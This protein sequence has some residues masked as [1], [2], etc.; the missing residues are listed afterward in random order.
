MKNHL[1]KLIF[2]GALATSVTFAAESKGA[3]IRALLIAGGCCHDY[4]GQ[5]K[6][7]S[8]GI[9]ERANV[10]VDV[11]WTDDKSV[12]PP[13]PIYED[14]NWA[15]GYDVVIHDE[16]AAGNKDLK[17]MENI[18]NAHKTVPAVHLH[19]A[20]HSFRN[21]TDQWFKH[22]GL[23]STRHGPQVPIK[24]EF[25]DKEHPIT[26]TL[27]DWTTI[28]EELYNSPKLYDAHT[29]ARGTQE[30]KGGKKE[31]SVVVWTNEKQGAR[32][33]STSL[34]HNTQTVAD[35]RYLDLVTRGLLWACDKL[36]EE[37]LKPYKGENKVTF[38]KSSEQPTAAP[39]QPK[40]TAAPKDATLVKMT[41]SSEESNKQNYAWKATDGNDQTRW[42]AAGGGLPAW[43]Q[44]E[45]D[46]PTT[47]TSAAIKWEVRN[48]W[49]QYKIDVSSDGKKW[50]TV[51]DKSNN[52]KGGDT[53]DEFEA[54]DVKFLRVTILKQQSSKWGSLWEVQVTGP[55]IK[56]IF[57]NVDEK[58]ITAQK[59]E[60]E[61][62][63]GGNV[64]PKIVKLT[65]GEEEQILKDVQVP[66]GFEATLFAPAATAN[67]P[68]Y[69]G[70]APN[71]DLYVSSDGNGSL[72]RSPNRGRILRL[73]DKDNDGRADEVTEFV[74]DIDAPRGIVW[75]HDRLYVLHPPHISVYFDKDGDGIAE[76][77]KRLIS[78]I[79]FG[80]DQRPPDHTTNGLEL[81][82]DGWIYIAGGDF[83]F[84]DAVGTDGRH[85]QH[86]GGGVIRFRP[87]GTGLELFST[88]T[89]NILG[90][91]TSPLLDIFARDNT[92]DGGGW[93]VRF[94]HFSGLE[95]H[96]YP[97]M[98]IN[99]G[100]EHIK[101]L[102]DYGGGSGCGSVYIHEP[103]FPKEWAHAPFTCDWGRAGLFHHTVERK[104]ASFIETSPP[105]V[106]IK[107]TRPTD[108]DVD[109]MSRVYQASWRGPATFNWAGPEHGYITRVSPKGYQPEPLPD[110]DALCDS[111]LVKLLES[112]SH[113]RTLTAQRTLLRRET[114]ES[115]SQALLQL[116]GNPKSELRS[117]VAALFTLSQ[118]GLDSK[119]S[120]SV[121]ETIRPL[122]SDQALAPFV[123]RALGDMGID[124]VTDGKKGSAPTDLLVAGVQSK[125]PRTRTEAIIAAARQ[126][127]KDAAN[128]IAASLG[129]E[130]P[131]IA[132][133]AFRALAL[134]ET[135]E[136][137]LDILNTSGSSEAQKQGASFALM[138]MH[139]K[140][141]VDALIKLLHSAPEDAKSHIL[142]AL[143]RLYHR[144]A[145]WKGDSWGTRPDTRGPYYQLET[146]E[147]SEKIM[148][149]LKHA[150]ESTKG[151][152]AARLVTEMSRNRI[153][154]N[155]ALTRIIEL[156]MKDDD[157]IETA[158]S[159]L[160]NMSDIPSEAIPLLLKAANNP[161][162]S[163]EVLAQ[164]IR[165]LTNVNHPESL[166]ATLSA[167]D[168]LDTKSGEGKAQSQGSNAFLKNN[169]L[170]S[171]HQA[172]AEIATVD[173]KSKWALAGL[174]ELASRNN[175]SPEAKASATQAINLA[176]QNADSKLLLIQLAGEINSHYLDGQI[177]AA[178]YDADKNVVNAA[179]NAAKRLRIQLPG[180][181]KT[182]K[183]ATL[184]PEEAIAQA[185]DMKGEA[186]LGEAVFI[187]AACATCHTTSMDEAQKGP[188]LGNIANTYRRKD[189][190][191]SI[192]NPNKSI[193]QGFATN[194]ITLKDKNALMGFITK[195]G[196]DEVRIRDVAA[197]EHVVKKSQIANRQTLPTSVMPPALMN[198]F[199]VKEFASLL[200]YLEQLSKKK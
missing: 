194:L 37:H 25:T 30:L 58:V 162:S 143:T 137:C 83:G 174:L 149:A 183:I 66:E 86:R 35:P 63:S 148:N 59:K 133:T 115:T 74:K 151:E 191:E 184:K 27:K 51:A 170:D 95:D 193:A 169:K 87:D 185:F 89:R 43:V 128:A 65:P 172:L 48:E 134:L 102:A 141:V 131:R 64:S 69:V 44:M 130:D 124:Q 3:K 171:H 138:R 168:A 113:I 78:G 8:K 39:E 81:G 16:C 136:P 32:S 21:G 34:G 90:T 155:A 123:M 121:I 164:S 76:D 54:R 68:V 132:H 67:Y 60:D 42:C 73:R 112:P 79:A 159:Q 38:I 195:E 104:G 93:N 186:G 88:G 147:E 175:S 28:N 139:R 4:A 146:W 167:L 150:L 11:F 47:L 85:L 23:Q 91:P 50:E 94:H 96:G 70:A 114:S 144:E 15:K 17:V 106:F 99:F 188:Y 19:C 145:E 71:G 9:S 56:S 178:L 82:I 12:N 107:V 52:T 18:L 1:L 26:A 2:L 156:A 189:L 140:E 6:V 127:N 158:V 117:R 53:K 154:N 173:S 31:E 49:Y 103:G 105:K 135:P 98:Y 61:F 80:F 192:I 33:F 57:P 196:A 118:R 163:A 161:D 157:L 166:K 14:P 116:A 179:Q 36:D 29:L 200:D 153:Q 101:P 55:E 5:T 126:K 100:D 119:S 84:M 152:K 10:Q 190:A 41:A 109:G 20:M 22:L 198:N 72:G 45:F 181:D 46:K 165:S 97:R 142:S 77:S 7:L 180:E 24:I 129:N 92:N 187:R 177:L 62:K 199:T 125:D 40:S 13:L 122:A 111:E 160:A 75:D 120:L 108:A 110:F 182:P 197:N 176:W